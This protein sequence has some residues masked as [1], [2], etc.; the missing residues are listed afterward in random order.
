MEEEMI[1]QITQGETDEE[2]RTETAESSADIIIGSPL[3]EK[4]E[5]ILTKLT[6]MET[7]MTRMT[8]LFGGVFNGKSDK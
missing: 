5:E 7:A 6:S 3:E 4:V 8:G 2:G 1:L